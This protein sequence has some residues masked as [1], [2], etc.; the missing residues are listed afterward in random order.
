[1]SKRA[2]TAPRPPIFAWLGPL[3][4]YAELGTEGYPRDVRRRLTIVNTMAFLI[5]F[6]SVVYAAVFAYYDAYAYRHLIA[7]NLLLMVIALFVPLAHRINDVAAAILIAAIEYTALFLFVRAFGRELGIQIN[8]IIAAAVAFAI[9]SLSHLRLA[10]VVMAIGLALHL[11]TWFLYPQEK[12]LFQA[13]PSLLANLYISSA[14]TTFCIIALIVAY[15]FSV[16]D[17]ARAEAEL[18]ACQHLAV[19]HRRAA[20]GAT[21]GACRRQRR[22][23]LGAVQRSGRLHRA[24]AEARRA[25]H[26]C[27]APSHRH[28]IRSPGRISWRGEDQ[29]HRRRLHGGHRRQP[30]ARR[31][32]AVS[33]AHGAPAAGTRAAALCRSRRRSQDPRRHRHRAG[34]GGGDRHRQ[35]LL[36]RLGRDGESC[37]AARV[38]MVFPA[39]S[40]CRAR[41]GTR[42]AQ[43]SCSRRVGRSRSKASAS[44][45]LGCSR[46]NVLRSR[47]RM[48]FPRKRESSKHERLLPTTAFVTAGS[49]G[50]A[51]R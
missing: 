1:M 41:S 20:Q 3:S 45:R 47:Y 5:A 16:A 50:Q 28:R 21:R 27:S 2:T 9:Y 51:G 26:R 8:Y 42:L 30:P 6:F 22:R 19:R 15:A 46:P 17:Q 37:L 29:D 25:A 48:S 35:I 12:A 33:G 23:G 36:R 44:S 13:E 40:R 18:A 24:C 49:P 11:A 32:S 4:G 38:R 43:A 39:R 31:S 10:V 14:V 7:I 34:D